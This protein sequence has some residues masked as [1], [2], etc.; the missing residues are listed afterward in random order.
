MHF[1][2]FL[3][4]PYKFSYEFSLFLFNYMYML[5]MFVRF[6]C[7]IYILICREC[8][9][10]SSS[11]YNSCNTVVSMYFIQTLCYF[12]SIF[13]LSFTK[14]FYLCIIL[15]PSLLNIQLQDLKKQQQKK[16]TLCITCELFNNFSIVQIRT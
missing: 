1:F 13:V 7:H 14:R 12:I 3:L 11:H 8:F 15:L 6:P 16:K 9:Y 2:S 5:F 4:A 10:I